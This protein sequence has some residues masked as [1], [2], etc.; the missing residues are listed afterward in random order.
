MSP[1]NNNNN[2]REHLWTAMQKD[3]GQWV[4]SASSQRKYTSYNLIIF[5]C[6]YFLAHK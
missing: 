3:H 4:F 1:G 6:A 5:L 2:N